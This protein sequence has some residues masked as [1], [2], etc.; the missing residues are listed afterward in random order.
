MSWYFFVNAVHQRSCIES[1][2]SHYADDILSGPQ[3]Q[4]PSLKSKWRYIGK[5]VLHKFVE[6]DIIDDI[7]A[8]SVDDDGVTQD[9]VID[10][11]ERA[12]SSLKAAVLHRLIFPPNHYSSGTIAFYSQYWGLGER[13]LLDDQKIFRPSDRPALYFFKQYEYMV[14]RVDSF[15]AYCK[16][17]V[18]L[19]HALPSSLPGVAIIGTPGIGESVWPLYPGEGLT[20]F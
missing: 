16:K 6:P 2:S 8:G 20:A 17:L 12:I 1:I 19:G 4:E 10:N 14:E 18:S 13:V 3:V 7:N 5:P 11:T 15:R 9:L